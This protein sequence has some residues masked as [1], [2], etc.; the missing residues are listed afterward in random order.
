MEKM[1]I[2][3]INELELQK[4]IPEKLKEY[5]NL[6]GLNV[7]NVADMLDLSAGMIS[8]WENGKNYPSYE[9]L[10]MLCQIYKI[11]ISDLTPM[12]NKKKKLSAQEMI[13]IEQYRKADKD[14]RNVVE[15][16]LQITTKN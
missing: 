12:G 15:K 11:D 2:Q 14:V 7:R 13:L 5:R 9:Q 4:I 6:S 10:I 8:N 16:I 1:N 3:S